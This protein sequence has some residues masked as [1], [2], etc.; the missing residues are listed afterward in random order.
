MPT[1]LHFIL[2]TTGE[3]DHSHIMKMIKGNFARKY[4][5]IHSREGKVW[6]AGFYDEGLRDMNMLLQKIEYIHNNPVKSKIVLSSD[7]YRFSSY[8]F[9]HSKDYK[10]IPEI[11][12]F[13]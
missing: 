6:Q 11:D 7:Q 8:A 3:Y 9:Y 10:G 12:I 2:Q 1:H 5:M 4:N 13:E